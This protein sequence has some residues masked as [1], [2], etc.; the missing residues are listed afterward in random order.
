[1]VSSSLRPSPSLLHETISVIAARSAAIYWESMCYW[2]KKDSRDYRRGNDH[3]LK[4]IAGMTIIRSM[5]QEWFLYQ[6]VLQK[7]KLYDKLAHIDSV[8]TCLYDWHHLSIKIFNLNC[9]FKEG[10]RVTTNDVIDMSVKDI[11]NTARIRN[12]PTIMP[13]FSKFAFCCGFV[14]WCSIFFLAIF[15]L[16]GNRLW[17]F[18]PVEIWNAR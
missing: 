5:S 17:Y 14:S 16:S 9:L 12:T 1:M 8:C 10:M 7:L 3:Y 13:A 18:P 6:D 15:S 2:Y 4:Y 11:V